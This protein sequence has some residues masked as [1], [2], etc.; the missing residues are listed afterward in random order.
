MKFPLGPQVP[1]PRKI[2]MSSN[3]SAT[4][5]ACTAHATRLLVA[6]LLSACS[7]NAPAIPREVPSLPS[8]PA[9]LAPVDAGGSAREQKLDTPSAAPAEAP[10]RTPA[11]AA[12]APAAGTKDTL[13][14]D[15]PNP[16][17]AT[18]LESVERIGGSGTFGA[19]RVHSEF[20]KRMRAL[21]VCYEREL[22]SHQPSLQ[23]TVGVEFTIE[24]SGTVSRAL[25]DG[26][27][28]NNANLDTCVNETMKRFRFN[29]TPQGGNVSYR[30]FISFTTPNGDPFR[31]WKECGLGSDP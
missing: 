19:E 4:K 16:R 26:G 13:P 1:L 15:C 8:V 30:I 10:A 23:G 29:P 14:T 25:T 27:T 5:H 22:R 2:R 18:K 20:K 28:A 3:L 24:A 6:L 9:A 12:D 7:E 17:F 21:Q 31:C 11:K